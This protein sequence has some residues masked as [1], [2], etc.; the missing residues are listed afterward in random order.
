MTSFAERVGGL[1]GLERL[2]RDH[3]DRHQ[4]CA[5]GTGARAGGADDCGGD[6]PAQSPNA[7]TG[8]VSCLL[9]RG[10]RMDDLGDGARIRQEAL[11]GRTAVRGER[12]PHRHECL[13]LVHLPAAERER[14]ADEEPEHDAEDRQPPARGDPLP[15]RAEVDFLL[16][17]E[18]FWRIHAGDSTAAHSHCALR[19]CSSTV[20][21][22]QPRSA[23]IRVVSA[24][25][26]R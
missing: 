22:C 5:R 14:E 24:F 26:R 19:P 9:E 1:L 21:G 18:V 7:Q 6:V 20:L 10:L 3:G 11:H 4:R 15:D 8:G 23:V 16:G 13:R 2:P 12:L 25:V 17:V